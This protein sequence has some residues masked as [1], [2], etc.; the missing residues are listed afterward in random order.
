MAK[1][2][3]IVESPAKAKTINKI[4]GKDYLVKASL[5]HVRDL[6][7]KELG[8]DIE[9]DFKP[10]YVNSIGREK[11]LKELREAAKDVEHVFLAPD[12]DRE[13]EAIAW[14]LKEVLK[15]IVK[16][17][18]AFSRVT[19]N[20]ITPT[21]IKAAFSHPGK[22]DLHKVDAQQAR[23]VLDRIVGYQ[24]SPMLWRTIRGAASAGRVQTI[25]LRLVCEREKEIRAFVP[26]KYWLVGAKVRKF[27]APQ[28]PFEIRLARLNGEKAEVRDQALADRIRADLPK[29][30]L[31]VAQITRKTVSRRAPPPFITSTLQQAASNVCGFSPSRTMSL[32]QKLYEGRDINGEGTVGLITYMRTDSVALSKDAVESIR[33]FV[34][35]EF[36][37]DFLPE[38]GNYY[39]SREGAQEAHEAIRPTDV[40]HTPDSLRTVLDPAEH[41]LYDLIWRRAVASQMAAAKIDQLSV[42]IDAPGRPGHDAG[43]TY[44]FRANSS[45]VIFPGYMRVT[46]AEKRKDDEVDLPPLAEGEMLEPLEWIDD[47][48]FTQ[49][50]SRYSE[51]SLIK[52][53]EENGVGRPSTYASIITTIYD[54]K[55][56]EAEKRTLRPTDVGMKVSDFLVAQLPELFDVQFTARM[57]ESLDEVEKGSVNWT[58][59]LKDF[60]TRFEGWVGAAKRASVDPVKLGRML[61]LLQNVTEWAPAVKRGKTGKGKEYSDEKFTQEVRELLASPDHSKMSARMADNLRKVVCRYHA[62]IPGWN[63]EMAKELGVADLLAEEIVRNQPPTPESIRKLELL[64]GLEYDEP[65]TIGKKTYDD[66]EFI[67]SFFDQVR[68]GRRLT[69]NQMAVLD[70]IVLRYRYQIPDFD[71]IA[72]EIG[73]NPEQVEDKESGPL[74]ALMGEVTEFAPAVERGKRVWSD[75][76]FYQSLKKQFETRKNLSPKQRFSLRRLVVRYSTKIPGYEAAREALNLP[77]PR[78]AKPATGARGRKGKR[79]APEE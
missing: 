51:A 55:Y 57:E 37:P 48:K 53:M 20:E 76:E 9:K 3:V 71:K 30:D 41:K 8:V 18:G 65:R 2:L 34:A 75:E 6:P 35:G 43:L 67:G 36:G 78:A 25:A 15:T 49:P 52:A 28:D 40:R 12:P 42:D 79:S 39:S 11:V 13:G 58:L 74:L 38:K 66:K 19:Y 45:Q 27:E 10:K 5:G 22:L 44:T 50:P 56:V 46:G 33:G 54:R 1:N 70:R 24:V 63:D 23:R 72:P 62:Q 60:Y 59:M 47:E 61:E 68:G 17:D 7:Q 32:A 29:R 69:D 16:G 26:E 73:I 64:Q 4:L 77:E 21:A 31:K 14:H